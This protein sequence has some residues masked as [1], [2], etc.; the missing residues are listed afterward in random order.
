M[1]TG[2]PEILAGIKI[3]L[4]LVSH[5]KKFI[6]TKTRKTAGTSVESY[7][8]RYCMPEGEWQPSHTRQ[9]Y[10]SESGIIG[11]RGGDTTGY[12]WFNHMPAARIRELVGNEIWNSYYKF[13]IIRNPFEKLVSDFWMLEKFRKNYKLRK[14]IKCFIDSF[15]DQGDPI[16]R[17]TGKT[18]IERFRSWILKDG[19][20]QEFDRDKYLIDGEEC[21]DYFIY[22]ESLYEGVKTVC[23]TL[24]I[25]FTPEQMPSYKAG[26]KNTQHPTEDYYDQ[27]TKEIVQNLFA[28]EINRFGYEM[29]S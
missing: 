14:K 23:K 8:E 10:V 27:E 15:F 7:F 4:M 29:P 26:I 2:C 17:A 12:T 1:Q 25:P 5:R 13:T 6:F 22:F 16:D 20:L 24:G 19:P 11:Y 9:E 21:V 28:W 18:E 3:E